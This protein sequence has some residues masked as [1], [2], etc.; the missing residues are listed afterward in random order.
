MNANTR[1]IGDFDP[2]LQQALDG[3]L[4]RQ[5]EHIELIASENYTSPWVLR[6]QGSVL[7]V[8]RVR[9]L[10]LELCRRY[11][12]YGGAWHNPPGVLQP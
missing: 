6:A 9:A 11:P 12:V 10:V 3:E 1:D 5:E 7:I 4:R 2:A 8:Q